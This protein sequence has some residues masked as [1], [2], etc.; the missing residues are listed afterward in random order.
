VYKTGRSA[1]IPFHVKSSTTLVWAAT[2][3]RI[4]SHKSWCNLLRHH[5]FSTQ[6]AAHANKNVQKYALSKKNI[7]K[8]K[9]TAS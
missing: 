3:C 4:L 2:S 5:S 8:I 6:K 9:E 1:A 7:Q